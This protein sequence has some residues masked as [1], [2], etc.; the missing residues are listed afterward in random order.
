MLNIFIFGTNKIKY[1]QLLFYTNIG[2]INSLQIIYL[3]KNKERFDSDYI[4]Y[5]FYF[6]NF[7]KK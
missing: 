3:I 1:F 4:F 6:I 5:N 7:Y 2:V